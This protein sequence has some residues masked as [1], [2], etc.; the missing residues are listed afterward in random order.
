MGS[1]T[2]GEL[3][4]LGSK[5]GI[6]VGVRPSM[7]EGSVGAGSTIC[8]CTFGINCVLWSIA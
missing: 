3:E 5:V 8:I 2:V 1:E 7:F 4:G 6:G